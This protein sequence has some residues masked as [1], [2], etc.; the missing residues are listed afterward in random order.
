[1]DGPQVAPVS[2]TLRKVRPTRNATPLSKCGLWR[3]KWQSNGSVYWRWLDDHVDQMGSCHCGDN[4]LCVSIKRSRKAEGPFGGLWVE[5]VCCSHSVISV[6][7]VCW[8]ENLFQSCDIVNLDAIHTKGKGA[9]QRGT[10]CTFNTKLFGFPF[11]FFNT[12][13]KRLQIT[14]FHQPLN[15]SNKAAVEK[16]ETLPFYSYS[17]W[18]RRATMMSKIKE[19]PGRTGCS[20]PVV[21]FL[22]TWTLRCYQSTKVSGLCQLFSASAEKI[23]IGWNDFT[24]SIPKKPQITSKSSLNIVSECST[25]VSRSHDFTVIWLPPAWSVNTCLNQSWVTPA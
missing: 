3:V 16:R 22:Y 14:E 7:A 18:I 21:C 5:T 4:P 6:Y 24:H 19:S 13:G 8:N 25:C 1:M 17:N 10:S 20:V 15:I 11:F 23:S 9:W 12:Y 2:S